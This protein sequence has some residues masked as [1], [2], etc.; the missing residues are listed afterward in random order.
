MGALLSRTPNE[1]HPDTA[2]AR[3]RKPSRSNAN[4]RRAAISDDEASDFDEV[5]VP[6]RTARK[7][8]SADE[9]SDANMDDVEAVNGDL[10]DEDDEDAEDLDEDE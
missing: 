5:A 9:E 10:A 8:R 6:V 1:N 2:M 7:S 3:I 4:N